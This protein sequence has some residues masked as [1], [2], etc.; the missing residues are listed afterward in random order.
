MRFKKNWDKTLK[1]YYNLISN[2]Y[3]HDVLIS[4]RVPW[5]S[6]DETGKETYY[7]SDP[8]VIAPV[9][10][11]NESIGIFKPDMIKDHE[12]D[13]WG[14]KEYAESYF[15]CGHFMF[16]SN[17]F[18]KKIIPDP[19]II[20]FGEEHTLALRAWTNDFRIFNLKESVVFHL[21]KTPEYKKINEL[22]DWR[23]TQPNKG[24][25]DYNMDIY[26][27]VLLGKE[28]GFFAAKD[29]NQYNAYI[30]AMGCPYTDLIE[31]NQI[32]YINDDSIHSN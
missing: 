1:Y 27:D 20:F 13:H 17:V 10:F 2:D 32:N 4:S 3:C 6:K 24:P 7:D 18:F 30:E 19:R 29:K 23:R 9:H 14:N 31:E 25:L 16:S 22:N 21:G 5:F 15:V 26:K 8:G 11:W 12:I 28:F